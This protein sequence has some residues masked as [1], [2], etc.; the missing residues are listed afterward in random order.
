V[1]GITAEQRENAMKRAALAATAAKVY[2]KAAAADEKIVNETDPDKKAKLIEEREEAAKYA[3]EK[4][5]VKIPDLA[6]QH[7][8]K[9]KKVRTVP[10]VFIAYTKDMGLEYLM[11]LSVRESSDE[12][13]AMANAAIDY[14]ITIN[15]GLRK[16]KK[17]LITKWIERVKN[18]NCP[19]GYDFYPLHG[20]KGVEGLCKQIQDNKKPNP[21]RLQ[22]SALAKKGDMEKLAPECKKPAELVEPEPVG[23]DVGPEP[24]PEESWWDSDEDKNLEES[25]KRR[26][27]SEIKIIIG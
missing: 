26:T 14:Y 2:E 12:L 11:P 27:K 1:M 19:P 23:A 25:M 9:K 4:L 20:T 3:E 8:I 17:K 6:G 18:C 24:E 15:P 13:E 22:F 10:A 16:Q 21:N 5:G 7:K